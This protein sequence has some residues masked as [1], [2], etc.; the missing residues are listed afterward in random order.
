MIGESW[1]G[2]SVVG[3]GQMLQ[4]EPQNHDAAVLHPSQRSAR[5]ECGRKEKVGFG[6]LTH[7]YGPSME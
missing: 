3:T 4:T 7:D 6:W 5:P 1:G 2:F